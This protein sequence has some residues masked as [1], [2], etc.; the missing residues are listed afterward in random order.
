[1]KKVSAGGP[2]LELHQAVQVGFHPDSSTRTG[3]GCFRTYSICQQSLQTASD[4]GAKAIADTG[5]E[6]QLLVPR[7]S[8]QQA[9]E[10]VPPG[11]K[12][13]MTPASRRAGLIFRQEGERRPGA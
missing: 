13:I 12:P 10:C 4:P 9:A 8:H 1:M 11:T 5:H 3:H 7:G 2:L 6:T